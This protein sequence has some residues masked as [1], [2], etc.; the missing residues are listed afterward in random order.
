VATFYY[1]GG[2]QANKNSIGFSWIHNYWCNLL[3]TMA[4]NGQPN[5]AQPIAITAMMILCLSLSVFWFLFPAFTSLPTVVKLIIRIC[6]VLAMVTGLLLFAKQNHDL[7]TNLASLFG[8]I[9][10]IGTFAGL[11]KNGWTPLFYFGLL[12]FLLVVLNN[13]LYYNKGLIVYLP[14]VQKITFACFLTWVCCISIKIFTGLKKH[15]W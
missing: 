14:I 7:I 1:P 2:S 10:T 3:D 8:L 11:Y 12:V 5:S 9:A 15:G 13:F 6:G 4:I